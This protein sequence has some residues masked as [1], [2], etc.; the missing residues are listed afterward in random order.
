VRV[1]RADELMRE[2]AEVLAPVREEVVVIGAIAVR[3]ALDGHAAAL[4][5]TRDVDGAVKTDA[6][7]RVVAQLRAA[8]LEPS[9]LPHERTFTWVRGQL[10]VQLLRPFHPFPKGAARGLPVSNVIPELDHYRELVAFEGSPEAPRLW[11]A[12]AAALVGLKEAAFGRVRHDGEMVDRDFSDVALLLDRVG[13]QIAAEVRDASPMRARVRTAAE[14]LL[15]DEDANA[16]AAR[17][18]VR[19]GEHDTQR[20]GQ[21]AVHRAANRL[22]RLLP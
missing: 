14:R 5:P 21:L 1:V 16:A 19:M 13:D 17:E 18:L 2:A 12:T 4:T 6:V 20:A 8:R 3:I 9:P 15:D 22:L 11:A 10:K 7:D